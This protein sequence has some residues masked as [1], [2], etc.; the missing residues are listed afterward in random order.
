MNC[1][2][3]IYLLLVNSNSHQFDGKADGKLETNILWVEA[4]AS[5]TVNNGK[6]MKRGRSTP[7]IF[8]SY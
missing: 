7:S 5:A 3:R 2:D 8:P 4:A 6:E 1:L